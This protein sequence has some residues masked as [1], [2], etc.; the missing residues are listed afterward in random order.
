MRNKVLKSVFIAICALSIISC[1]DKNIESGDMPAPSYLEISG[2]I[3]DEAGAPLSSISISMDTTNLPARRDWLKD[4][5]S[6]S[7]KDGTYYI[8]SISG[9]HLKAEEWPSILS[10]VTLIA[11][12]TTGVYETQKKT[13][14]VEVLVRY[15]EQSIWKDLVDGYVTADFVMKKK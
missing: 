7:E 11:E 4:P 1:D 12:D 13:V 6:F 9:A 2:S 10:E 5:S 8:F 3:T 15:P 14:P